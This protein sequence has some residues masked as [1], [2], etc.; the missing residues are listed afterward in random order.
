MASTT[1]DPECRMTSRT[2][3]IPLGSVTWSRVTWK[4]RPWKTVF[5]ERTRGLPDLRLFEDDGCVLRFGGLEVA[6]GPL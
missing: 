6:M 2:A 5:D 4:T 1:T 3:E